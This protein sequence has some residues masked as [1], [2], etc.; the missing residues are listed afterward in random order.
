MTDDV[1]AAPAAKL[2]ACRLSPEIE[3]WRRELNALW[4]GVGMS[5]N[6]FAAGHPIDKGTISRYLSG[7]RVPRDPWFLNTL[8]AIR[9]EQGK[10][11][12]LEV[13][14][15]LTGLQLAALQVAHPSEYRVRLVS[16]HL[17]LAVV[18][19]C[20]AERYAEGLEGELAER[21]REIDELRLRKAKL[22]QAWDTDRAVQGAEQRRLREHIAALKQEIIALG[23]RLAYA[24]RR[25]KDAERRCQEL[26]RLL[27]R[28]LGRPARPRHHRSAIFPR[29]RA[30]CLA[31]SAA[32]GRD[33]LEFADVRGAEMIAALELFGFTCEAPAPESGVELG[34]AV[35]TAIEESGKGDLLAVVVVGHGEMSNSGDLHVVGPD[36]KTPRETRIVDWVK[37]VENRPDGPHVLFFVDLCLAGETA[38]SSH[39]GSPARLSTVFFSTCPPVYEGLFTKAVAD[40]LDKMGRKQADIPAELEYIPLTM[41]HGDIRDRF[42][43]LI[44]D[45]DV[46]PQEVLT[47][48]VEFRTAAQPPPFFPN[49]DAQRVLEP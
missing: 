34:Q 13:R 22:Q 23:G 27:E 49:P 47:G 3:A 40:V 18:A 24:H 29:R 33:P 14:E 12:A 28:L 32:P 17:E 36:G 46:N 30:I 37:E 21:H 25:A 8:L 48:L 42:N 26:E 7:K 41:V 1:P 20:E 43:A 15:H 31:D 9:A 10:E 38:R 4:D 11:V 5:M 6:R 39:L 44:D 19:R 16:D 45:L 2:P 35:Y